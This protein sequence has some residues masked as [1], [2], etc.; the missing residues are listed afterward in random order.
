MFSRRAG[1]RC[2]RS[3]QAKGALGNVRAGRLKEKRAQGRDGKHQ[4][5]A[6]GGLLGGRLGGCGQQGKGAEN[7]LAGAGLLGVEESSGKK[8]AGWRLGRLS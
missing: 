6:H 5:K 4:D 1:Q 3:R 8:E 7:L 2:R